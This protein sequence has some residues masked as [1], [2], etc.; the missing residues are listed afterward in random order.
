MYI[1]SHCFSKQ[2]CSL[3]FKIPSL[4]LFFLLNS[5][6]SQPEMDHLILL[7][8]V[9]QLEIVKYGEEE[10]RVPVRG[11]Q[12]LNIQAVAVRRLQ[13]LVRRERWEI[14]ITQESYKNVRNRERQ[15][16]LILVKEISRRSLNLVKKKKRE[17]TTLSASSN[18]DLQ[19]QKILSVWLVLDGWGAEIVY[20]LMKGERE[21]G[22]KEGWS[23]NA[24]ACVS[25]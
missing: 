5:V 18:M 25:L 1:L 13:A 17:R 11:S 22:E 19:G 24:W 20:V 15:G 14:Q 10:L 6:Y 21:Q 7:F 9:W 4:V 2:N 8:A 12:G 3:S 16:K 23:L